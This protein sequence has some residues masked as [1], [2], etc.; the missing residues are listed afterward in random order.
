MILYQSGVVMTVRHS[1]TAV[2][3]KELLATAFRRDLV[4]AR[5]LLVLQLLALLCPVLV[6]DVCL[7]V[8]IRALGVLLIPQRLSPLFR[9]ALF[10]LLLIIRITVDA[11]CRHLVNVTL[12][13][14]E[15]VQVDLFRLF[16][17][18]F[19]LDL[20]RNRTQVNLLFAFLTSLGVAFDGFITR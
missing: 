19:T 5:V 11:L 10:L 14:I 12:I 7:R 18:F 3:C 8:I 6:L 17:R 9:R 16:L 2:F 1:V 13:T 20:A 15:L 4:R